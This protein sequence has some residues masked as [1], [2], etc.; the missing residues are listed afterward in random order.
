[1]KKTM[2]ALAMACVIS[3]VWTDAATADVLEVEYSQAYRTMTV[4]VNPRAVAVLDTEHLR[5]PKGEPGLLGEY[6][7]ISRG[8]EAILELEKLGDTGSGG[9]PAVS[10]IETRM[11]FPWGG[12]APAGGIPDDWFAARWTGKLGPLP[13]AAKLVTV[14][15]DGV[16]LW[17]DGRKIIDDWTPHAQKPN[18][19]AEPIEAGRIYDVRLEFFE[20]GGG[21]YCQFGYR[22]PEDLVGRAQ[23]AEITLTAPDG[24]EVLRKLMTW[25]GNRGEQQWEIPD[26]PGG[27]YTVTADLPGVP[28]PFTRTVTVHGQTADSAKISVEKGAYAG[29]FK[30]AGGARFTV[31]PPAVRVET[32]RYIVE[33]IDMG[34]SQITDRETGFQYCTPGGMQPGRNASLALKTY[35]PGRSDPT[36]FHLPNEPDLQQTRVKRLKRGIEYSVKGLVSPGD[37]NTRRY[38]P[39]AVLGLRIEFEAA[40]G[41]LCLTPIGNAGIPQRF[42]VYDTGIFAVGFNAGPFQKNIVKLV[43]PAGPAAPVSSFR[44]WEAWWPTGYPVSLMVFEA[45]KPETPQA[46]DAGAQA[47][48][49]CVAIWAD[50]P[51]LEYGRKFRIDDGS[52]RFEAVN[53]DAP[54]RVG[55]MEAPIW[56][57]N[58]FDSWEPAAL[59]YREV[60]ERTMGVKKLAEREPAHARTIRTVTH[61]EAWRVDKLQ[62]FFVDKGV[63]PEALM[64]WETMG[65]LAGYGVEFLSKKRD[66][67]YPNYPFDSPTHYLGTPAFAKNVKQ[68][69]EFGVPVFPYTLMFFGMSQPF[70]KDSQVLRAPGMDFSGAGRMWWVLYGNMMQELRDRYGLLGIY[71]DCSWVAPRY[72]PRGKVDG[73]TVWQAHVEGRRYMKE[74]LLPAAFMGERQHEVTMVSDFIALLW[75]MGELHPINNYLF[76]PYTLRFNQQEQNQVGAW[77]SRG[78][79]DT[80]PIHQML[81]ACESLSVIPA[82]SH[83]NPLASPARQEMA[84]ISKRLLFWG[85]QMLTPFFPERYEPGVL[86]YLRGKDGTE[87]RTKNGGGMGLVR[88]KKGAEEIVWWRTANVAEFHSRGAAIDGWVGY[89]GDRIIGLNPARRY[90]LLEDV[91]RPPVKISKLPEGTFISRARVGEGFWVAGIEGGVDGTPVELTIDSGGRA[92]TFVG[93]EVLETGKAGGAYRVRVPSGAMFAACW[94]HEPVTVAELPA[95]LGEPAGGALFVGEAGVPVLV[96]SPDQS[97][98]KGTL[99][100]RS[101]LRGHALQ[102]DY[103]LTLPNAPAVLQAKTVDD[104]KVKQASVRVRINGRTVAEIKHEPGKPTSLRVALAEFAGQTVLLTLDATADGPLGVQ[105]LLLAK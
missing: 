72:D 13:F 22:L 32:E 88:V 38:N 51:Q 102:A 19:T 33:F 90:V 54:W 49:E 16:R 34:I 31:A 91:A 53:G 8:K 83:A 84:L 23:S 61:A 41:D 24:K 37:E 73:L 39:E 5:T 70:E 95:T 64:G 62:H 98:A 74:R 20:A 11:D 69:Q 14:T 101:N 45:S 86:G 97:A 93:A 55:A 2:S 9:E 80:Q 4:R 43:N 66:L 21:A 67:W 103:L 85:Q 29:T 94:K 56:R 12:G 82:V 17:L 42:G 87:Y 65:W 104:G 52:V 78:L 105:E 40:T 71:D 59:R 7:D 35:M 26:L 48:G 25:P 30:V 50:D 28:R 77:M 68:S 92:V 3:L 47:G 58:L 63:P 89:D 75:F 10:R 6:F 79:S 46:N 81:D 44:G 99:W 15:D 1:M 27:T 60:M 96:S 100:W 57:L 76:G 18:E 36:F